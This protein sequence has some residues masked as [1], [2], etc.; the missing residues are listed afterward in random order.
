MVKL[1]SQTFLSFYQN[2]KEHMQIYPTETNA[3]E[4]LMQND[5]GSTGS[6]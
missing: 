4:S 3:I 1:I 5:W 2:E 6:L